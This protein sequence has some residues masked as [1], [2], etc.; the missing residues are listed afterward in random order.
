MSERPSL[1]ARIEA[2]TREAILTWG[3]DWARIAEHIE[4]RL[5]ALGPLESKDVAEETAFTLIGA[6]EGAA[7]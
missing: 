2:W 6:D 4:R 5:T 7:H 3:Y 1:S